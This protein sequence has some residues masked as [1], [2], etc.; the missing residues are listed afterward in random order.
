MAATSNEVIPSDLA[1][2]CVDRRG[3]GRGTRETV[4]GE[5]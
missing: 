2:A 4:T 3:A 1:K 5:P